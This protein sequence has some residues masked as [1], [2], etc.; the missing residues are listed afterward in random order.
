MIQTAEQLTR[1]GHALHILAHAP[2][3]TARTNPTPPPPR[4][5][6]HRAVYHAVYRAVYRAVCLLY[7]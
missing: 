2:R 3:S 5:A 1:P 4:R 6:V 7:S